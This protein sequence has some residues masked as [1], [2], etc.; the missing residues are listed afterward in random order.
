MQ[1]RANECDVPP[2]HCGFRAAFSAGG[3]L[4][5]FGLLWIAGCNKATPKAEA[6]PLTATQVL[7]RMVKAYR[8][9]K[10]YA[11]SGQLQLSYS[12]EGVAP[13]TN[14]AD[15]SLAFVRPN[16]IRMHRYQAIIVSDGAQLRATLA[17]LPGQ[18]F[19]VP[20][21]AK[22]TSEDLYADEI[23]GSV[24]TQGIAGESIQLG[25][26]LLPDPLAPVLV[27]AQEPKLLDPQQVDDQECYR[28]EVSRSDGRFVFCIDR[29][30]F[31]LRRISYPTAELKQK[32]AEQEQAPISE[33][34]LVAEFK[35]ARLNGKIDDLAFRFELP[36]EAKLVKHFA[37]P[38][39]PLPQLLGQKPAPF[40][41]IGMDGKPVTP[42]ALSGKVVVVDY[43]A[44]W[45]KPCLEGQLPHLQK[46]YEKYKDNDR[47][48]IVA[49]SNDDPK[50]TNEELQAVFGKAGL[51]MPILR[52]SDEADLAL[53]AVE[54]WP[55]MI[56][57]GADGTVQA[58]DEGFQPQLAAD[59]PRKIDRLLAGENLAQR[60]IKDFESRQKS[61]DESV[62][63][64]NHDTSDTAVIPTAKIA[65]RTEP[66]RLKLASLWHSDEASKPG[67]LLAVHESDGQLRLL[68]L[69]GWQNVLELDAKGQ[70]VA[71][72][73]LQIPELSAISYLRTATDAQGNRYF[74][75]SASNQPQLFLFDGMFNKQLT[76]PEGETVGIS[77][78]RLADLD[79]DGQPELNVGYWG[80]TGVQ[81]VTLAGERRWS[82][83]S[84]ENVFCL[85]VTDPNKTGQRDLLAADLRGMLVPIDA[86]GKVGT[87]LV[88][89]GRV[90]RW[91]LIADVNADG[92]SE[93]CCVAATKPGVESVVSL[94]PAGHLLWEYNLPVGAQPNAALEMLTQG[95]LLGDKNWWVVAG[96]DGSIH[97]LDND[98]QL[99][100]RFNFGAAISGLAIATIDGRGALIV[101]T[102]K[103][104]DAW[105]I[106]EPGPESAD[107]RNK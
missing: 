46:V 96:P 59:L 71:Q 95:R 17:D 102:E 32:I 85:G 6:A 21:P 36:S 83:N 65:P 49:V 1:V 87:P 88:L 12:K 5:T 67:N 19:N 26:L 74:A 70:K 47:V 68:A 31:V 62:A 90:L 98:G 72:Y 15:D 63:S 37:I 58:I 22:L 81:N 48:A 91:A 18:V 82:N 16:K 106:D 80:M 28:V 64:G 8:D 33:V 41:F 79:G 43:W 39:Q 101:A 42:E 24:L 30:T 75:G 38:P 27:G 2:A 78:L 35:G 9:A 66:K 14:G 50:V 104:I 86:R 55:M 25:L 92:Q 56:L 94:S 7:D 107:S 51:T 11:D 60:A 61:F 54:R 44:T 45:C 97:F 20:A 100:D 57:L 40:K 103:G 69:D 93:Y 76:F 99:V 73:E 53:Y 84:I 105:Q 23:L 29:R 10:S 89:P 52:D 13:V 34:S 3:L 77:D 4:L